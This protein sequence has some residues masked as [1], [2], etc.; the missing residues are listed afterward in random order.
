MKKLFLRFWTKDLEGAKEIFE[1][2]GI[3][4]KYEHL[5]QT[6]YLN[7]RT[8]ITAIQVAV[9]AIRRTNEYH[10]EF[11]DND[12]NIVLMSLSAEKFFTE[13]NSENKE[14]LMTLIE[15]KIEA[16]EKSTKE[17][18]ENYEKMRK[19]RELEIEKIVETSL[20]PKM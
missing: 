18:N 11:Y 3:E 1:K 5:K 13:T 9:D 15:Q 19:D 7:D 12:K 6:I 8:G 16:F 20:S 14:K 10:I 17:I 4:L 2:Y